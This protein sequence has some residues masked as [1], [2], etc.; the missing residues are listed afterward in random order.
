MYQITCDNQIIYDIRSKDRIVTSPKLVLATGKNGTLSFRIPK[1]NPM[2]DYINLKKSIFRV[3]Q[4]DI[5]DKKKIYTQLFRGMATTR[6]EDFYSRGQISCEGELAF[7]NDSIIRPYKYNGDVID[8]F[9]KYVNEHN[10]KVDEQ[11]KF[12]VRNCTVTDSNNYI[13]RANENYPSTKEEM[14]NKL[15]G[16]LGGHFETEEVEE[17][18]RYGNIIKKVYIDYLAEYTKYNT[19]PIIFG[20]NILDFTKVISAEDIKTVIIPLGKK[21]E[22][23]YTTIESVNNGLD[24]IEDPAAINVFGRIEGIVKH[25]DV[26][27]P[28]N[29][30]KKGK[31]DLE[32]SI[33]LSTT[34]NITAADLHEL[35]VDIEALRIGRLTR[36]VSKPHKWDKYMLL[37]KLELILDNVKS[38]RVTLGKT[39]KTFT[40]KQLENQKQIASFTQSTQ[41]ITSLD[42]DMTQVKTDVSIINTV[43]TEDIP[44]EYVKTE[45][46]EKYKDDINSKVSRVYRIKGSVDSYNTLLSMSDV[47][48]GDVYNCKDTGANYVFTEEGW[49]KFSE[50]VDFSGY[51]TAEEA[52]KIYVAKTDYEELVA[53]VETLELQKEGGNIDG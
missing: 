1:T 18:D 52:E 43:I 32:D 11:K 10:S 48:E 45:T 21:E 7:F 17:V 47:E 27:V 33:N 51:I 9:K 13:T 44:T 25:D 4:V 14:D 5:K 36:V 19:Q 22:D 46:F 31:K 6:D 24:Y 37:T 29:L 26:T 8:L 15:I 2:F 35:N 23:K 34:I 12:Y 40:E 30:L 38:S 50:T 39:Y 16:Y 28:S 53:R 20:K 42:K 3:Y 49:D 41:K